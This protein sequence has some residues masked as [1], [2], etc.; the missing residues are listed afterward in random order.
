MEVMPRDKTEN[1]RFERYCTVARQELHGGGHETNGTENRS[2]I[3]VDNMLTHDTAK[4]DRR[5]RCVLTGV[6]AM[7]STGLAALTRGMV[8]PVT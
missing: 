1:R 2:D 6:I 5:Q 8:T 7:N 4:V 3:D